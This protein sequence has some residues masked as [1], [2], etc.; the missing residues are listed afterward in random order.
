MDDGHMEIRQIADNIY[1]HT[2]YMDTK[3]YGL[4]GSK[5]ALRK[6]RHRTSLKSDSI[7]YEKLRKRVW[8]H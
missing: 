5:K 3:S 4:V 6:K 2:S 1:L 7:D 8:I